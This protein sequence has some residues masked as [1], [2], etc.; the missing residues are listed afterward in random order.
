MQDFI[1]ALRAVLDQTPSRFS[2]YYRYAFV[3]V[4]LEALKTDQSRDQILQRMHETLASSSFPILLQR[5]RLLAQ[6]I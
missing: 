4:G 6:A 3:S 5:M 1:D 2:E